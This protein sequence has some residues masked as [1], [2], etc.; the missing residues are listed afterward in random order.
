MKKI[1]LGTLAAAALSLGLAVS[2]ASAIPGASDYCTTN[3]DFGLSHG[4]CVSLIQNLF[5]EGNSD[6]VGVCKLYEKFYP[7]IFYSVFKNLGQCVS[8]LR[9]A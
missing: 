3:S 5:N 9:T 2:P 8:S 7:G 4:D 1:L 6:A